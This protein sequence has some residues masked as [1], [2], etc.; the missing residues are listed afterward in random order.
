MIILARD[1]YIE[2]VNQMMNQ[3]NVFITIFLTVLGIVLAIFG[4]LQWK[5]SDNQIKN[6]RLQTK[7]ETIEEIERQLGVDNISDLY[8]MFAKISEPR[9]SNIE[10]SEKDIRKLLDNFQKNYLDYQLIEMYNDRYSSES[11]LIKIGNLIRLNEEYLKED[12]NNFNYFVWRFTNL[13]LNNSMPNEI[14]L[15][16][17]I[18]ALET[19]ESN[20]D[21]KSE[22]LKNL[23]LAINNYFK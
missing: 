12:L 20:F 11:S 5:I 2:V 4:F 10:Q 6:I 19:I 7:I 9:I 17:V 14:Q 23:K 18:D 21:E 15:K 16:M 3:Q 8:K 22:H 13:F 1:E